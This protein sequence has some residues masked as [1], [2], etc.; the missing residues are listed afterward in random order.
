MN[1]P[2][3]L[4]AILFIGVLVSCNS[5]PAKEVFTI[6]DGKV[7]MIGYGSLTSKKQM[8]AQLGKPYDGL[9]RVVHL[10]GF[11][12][13]WNFVAPNDRAHPPFNNII[14]CVAEG[15]TIAP[16]FSI[17][18]NIQR[19]ENRSINCCLFVIDET[20][21]QVM[22]KTEIGY[23]R[24]DVSDSIREFDVVGGP[25]YAYQAQP[26]YVKEAIT[27]RPGSSVI[28]TSY[29][30]FLEAAFNDLGDQYKQE[31]QESTAKYEESLVLD[32]Y[33]EPVE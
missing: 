1:L 20:D 2:Y 22:D 7:G 29:L 8:E 31:F 21:L 17:F 32:C 14:K 24:I 28:P 23:E 25:V 6:P 27:N 26:D 19:T 16:E 15:D 12:R 11:Q 5:K 3:S 18:L 30:D 4:L 10:D 9:F 33:L 13:Y